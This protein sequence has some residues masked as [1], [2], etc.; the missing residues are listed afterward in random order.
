[1]LGRSC[2]LAR[3]FRSYQNRGLYVRMRTSVWLCALA[4]CD[5]ANIEDKVNNT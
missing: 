1:M 4:K 5:G 3:I 2:V